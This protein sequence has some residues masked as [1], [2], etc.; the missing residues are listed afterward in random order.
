MTKFFL[1]YLKGTSGVTAIEYGLFLAGISLAIVSIVFV[2]GD[3]LRGVMQELAD[4]IEQ[5]GAEVGE[6]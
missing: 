3:D 2:F 4:A 1:E 5:A 6:G